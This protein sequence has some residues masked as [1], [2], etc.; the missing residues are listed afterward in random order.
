MK[1][2]PSLQLKLPALTRS[3]V[4]GMKVAVVGGTGGIGRALARELAILGADVIVVGQTFRDADLP[5][6]AFVGAD[7][8]LMSEARRVAS[9]LPAETLD[10]VVFT[11]GI[12]AAPRREETAE[13]IERDMA[14]SYL[15]RLVIL[16]DIAPRLGTRRPAGRPKARVFVMGYPGTG[17]AGKPGDLNAEQAYSA[18]GVH[19]NTVAGNEMLVLDSATR[20]PNFNVYGLNPGLIKTGIRSNFLGANKFLFSLIEGLIGLVMPTADTYARRIAPLLLAPQLESRSG[21]LFNNKAKAILPSPG[22]TAAHMASFLS[23]SHALVGRAR[24]TRSA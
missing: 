19:M 1:K 4:A 24:T 14:V 23:E 22:L 7:L 3:D 21:A 9:L 20:H 5:N 17:Q 18:M 8:G 11:T 12:F 15:S 6:M 10:L 16:Q 2:D 13:G